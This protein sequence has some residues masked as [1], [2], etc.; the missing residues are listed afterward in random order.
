LKL[1][2]SEAF[3]SLQGEGR[4]VGVPSVFLRTF[5]CNLTCAG[6]G[7]PRGN[8]IA[9]D[10]MPYMTDPRANPDHPEAYTSIDELPVTPIG[11][12]SSA[13]WA[14]KYKHLQLTRTVEEVYNHIVSLLPNGTFTGNHGEDIHLVITGGEPLL[15]WQR[16]WP[17]LLT[18]CQQNGLKNVTFETN[19]TQLVSHALEFFFNR[20]FYGTQL[21]VTWSTSPKL[22]VSGESQT[23]ALVPDALLTMNHVANS[24]LYTKFVV[25]DA[26]CF[27]EVDYFVDTYKQA[28]VKL[29]AVY[30]M[31]EGATLEQQTLTARDVADACLKTG[32]KYSP[33][34][35]ID[36]YGNAWGA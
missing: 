19:G 32:Y 17:E 12:D 9:T 27:Q 5:G 30:C 10:D 35:H 25:R 4:F 8:L 23:D 33:R 36:L 31:P 1:R 7:Q 29:D 16:V 21:H 2:Y 34:L 26:Q 3:A 28:G 11:C 18:L 13:S 20:S 15:G 24:F 22:S 14:V 6:F